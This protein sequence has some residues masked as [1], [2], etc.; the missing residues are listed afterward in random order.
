MR[1]VQTLVL[2]VRV[3]A[4]HRRSLALPWSLLQAQAAGRNQ[5]QSRTWIPFQ[6]SWTVRPTVC[7]ENC[8]SGPDAWI[9]KGMSTRFNSREERDREAKKRVKRTLEKRE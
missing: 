7:A 2:R 1:T 8:R 9:Q 4:L 3:Y 6:S 5:D